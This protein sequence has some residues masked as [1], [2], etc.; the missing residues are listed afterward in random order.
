[1]KYPLRSVLA[2]FIFCSAAVIWAANLPTPVS[3]NTFKP[4][5][6][7]PQLLLVNKNLKAQWLKIT[8]DQRDG[9]LTA[10]QAKTLREN[11][12]ATRKQVSSF[13]KGNS[14]HDLTSDQTNQINQQIQTNAQSI[15]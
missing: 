3:N 13:Y 11:L 12:K 2:A 9:K 5:N 10:A 7:K 1:M 8:T 6:P 14:N 15:P 4:S